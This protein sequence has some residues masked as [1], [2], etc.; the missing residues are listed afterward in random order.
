MVALRVFSW[1]LSRPGK[2][3]AALSGRQ[4]CPECRWFGASSGRPVMGN[5]LRPQQPS[6]PLACLP[7]TC[8]SALP[9]PAWAPSPVGLVVIMGKSFPAPCPGSGMNVAAL[10]AA[11]WLPIWMGSGVGGS[12]YASF[13]AIHCLWSPLGPSL[14]LL[15]LGLWPPLRRVLPSTGTLSWF[16]KGPSKGEPPG[17]ASVARTGPGVSQDR[18]GWCSRE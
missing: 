8:A 14:D 1:V 12:G 17:D 13:Q 16:P 3:K 2:S 18:R 5:S 15:W 11:C 9:L 6:A 4:A 7:A 10:G